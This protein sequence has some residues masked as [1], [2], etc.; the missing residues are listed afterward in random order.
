LVKKGFVDRK[1]CPTNR[2][3]VDI[4][5]TEKGIDFYYKVHCV[6]K[7]AVN[8]YFEDRLYYEEA[9]VLYKFLGKIKF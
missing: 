9:R 5:V 1:T 6:A 3:E 2:R 8:N 4:S 7:E